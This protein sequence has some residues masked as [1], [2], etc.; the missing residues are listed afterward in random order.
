M[1]GLQLF[2]VW[3]IVNIYKTRDHSIVNLCRLSLRFDNCH[4]TVASWL[5]QLAEFATLDLRVVSLS[6]T[7]GGEIISN[8][9][10]NFKK[11]LLLAS[12]IPKRF[13]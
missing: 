12:S 11:I 1:E 2:L 10:I 4:D 6:P 7:L 9:L 5:V 3:K 13:F 8:K